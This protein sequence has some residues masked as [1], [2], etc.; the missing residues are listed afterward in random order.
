VRLLR[1]VGDA[2]ESGEPLFEIH[3]ESQMQLGFA[4]G[5]AEARP[6]LVRL[7]HSPDGAPM[8]RRR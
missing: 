3:A 4:R 5:H 7:S 6:E 1:G 2:V 8:L